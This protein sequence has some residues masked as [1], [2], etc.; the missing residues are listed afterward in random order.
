MKESEV[1]STVTGISAQ[2]MWPGMQ[3]MPEPVES[4][5]TTIRLYKPHRPT[6]TTVQYKRGIHYSDYWRYRR[7]CPTCLLLRSN[8]PQSQSQ[9]L[10]NHESKVGRWLILVKRHRNTRRLLTFSFQLMP[11]RVATRLPYS[12]I[13]NGTL[14]KVITAG[15]NLYAVGDVTGDFV[16]VNN[17][18]T[19]FIPATL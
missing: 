11:V 18:A 6:G 4:T 9:S 2:N 14:I 13:W 19:A 3:G 8:W 7:V 1:Y 5:I 10:W 15:H 17:H 16:D 12:V